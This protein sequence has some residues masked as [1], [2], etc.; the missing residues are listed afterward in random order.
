MI[1]TY[2]NFKKKNFFIKTLKIR[3]AWLIAIKKKNSLFFFQCSSVN[4]IS[5][6][7][8][9]LQVQDNFMDWNDF[10]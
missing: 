10:I 5:L 4:E 3:Y 6:K 7:R 8:I 2:F 9:M 1:I